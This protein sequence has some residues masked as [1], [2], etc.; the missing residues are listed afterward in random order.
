MNRFIKTLLFS[1]F[2]L[3][4]QPKLG[5]M[6][7]TPIPVYALNFAHCQELF[8]EPNALT[9]F[10]IKQHLLWYQARGQL[11][12]LDLS[13]TN[14]YML[15][16]DF[17]EDVNNVLELNLSYNHFIQIPYTLRYLARSL[18]TLNIS[19][20][21]IS[22]LADLTV[23][24]FGGLLYLDASYNTIEIISL[25]P[26]MLPHL[27]TCNLSHNHISLVTPEL[28]HLIRTTHINLD[29]NPIP[30]LSEHFCSAEAFDEAL[31]Q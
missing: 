3:S 4:K 29:G 27:Q 5:A 23:A 20:N 22:T 30:S 31:I 21:N 25:N 1:F 12:H 16:P 10:K 26:L 15:P 7:V 24:R 18:G 8:D 11:V 9:F 2:L 14:L 13:D 28:Q 19:H 6:I 17:F